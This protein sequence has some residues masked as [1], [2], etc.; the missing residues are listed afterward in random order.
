M[1]F[2]FGAHGIADDYY[3]YVA[4]GLVERADTLPELGAW[5]R[6]YQQAK[7][8]DLYQRAAYYNATLGTPDE[9]HS[10]QR[11]VRLLQEW[12]AETAPAALA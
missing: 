8:L 2:R 7:P 10:Q 4:H 11:A 3:G 12:L 6:R 5:L 1:Y 9:G